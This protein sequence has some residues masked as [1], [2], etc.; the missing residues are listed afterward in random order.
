MRGWWSHLAGT[1]AVGLKL[2]VRPSVWGPGG[3]I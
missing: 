1:V 2:H 3:P